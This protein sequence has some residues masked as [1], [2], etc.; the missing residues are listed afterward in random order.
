MSPALW[1]DLLGSAWIWLDL[2]WLTAMQFSF[3]RSAWLR[4]HSA[5]H[6]HPGRGA[7]A[8]SGEQRTPARLAISHLSPKLREGGDARVN[9]TELQGVGL[10]ILEVTNIQFSVRMVHLQLLAFP[11]VEVSSHYTGLKR[12]SCYM[13]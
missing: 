8:F 7:G 12:Q 10:G 6:A 9:G 11:D 4:L 3:S 2:L 1:L 13:E 5:A